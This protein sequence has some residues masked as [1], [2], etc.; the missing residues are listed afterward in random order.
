MRATAL[1][2]IVRDPGSAMIRFN[3]DVAPGDAGR[4]D[5]YADSL[6]FDETPSRKFR[7]GPGRGRV[8]DDAP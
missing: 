6:M 3:L 5:A 8:L 7:G 2:A 1:I 4:L